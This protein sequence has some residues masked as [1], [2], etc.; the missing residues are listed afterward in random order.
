MPRGGR[1]THRMNKTHPHR[2][3]KAMWQRCRKH[4]EYVGRILVCDAW[5]SFV[6]FYADMGDPPSPGHTL[7]RIDND[8][9]Y[10]PSN[11]RWATRQEQAENRRNVQP[12]T[13]G[14]RTQTIK[15]WSRE[16]GVSA[17]TIRRRLSA[18][19]SVEEAFQQGKRLH[20]ARLSNH[21]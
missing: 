1:F 2:A 9:G 6:S 7:D 3:W 21:V 16:V 4:P 10:G 5:R 20:S 18:G 17:T 12:L 14:G 15:A 8:Q 19:F 13:V 11:C